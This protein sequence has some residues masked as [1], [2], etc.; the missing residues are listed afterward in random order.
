MIN[1]NELRMIKAALALIDHEGYKIID[2]R[3]I[4]KEIW[5]N[6][7][8]NTKELIRFSIGNGFQPTAHQDERTSAI[9]KAIEKIFGEKTLFYDV[10]FD[11]D[12]APTVKTEDSIA[13]TLAPSTQSNEF[14][15]RFQ[16][17]RPILMAV[18]ED[19]KILEDAQKRLAAERPKAAAPR[20]MVPP[21]ATLI[22]IILCSIMFGMNSILS[23]MGHYAFIDMSIFLGAYYKTLILSNNE[24]WRFFTSGFLHM[25]IY[26]LVM[27]MY[28]LYYLGLFYETK[29]GWKKMLATLFVGVIVGSAF[30]F[31]TE[32]NVVAVGM[33]GGLFAVLGSIV[34][35]M[36]ESGQIANKMVQRQLMQIL[37]INVFISLIPGVAFMAHLGGFLAGILIALYFSYKPSWKQLKIHVLISSLILSSALTYLIVNDKNYLPVTKLTDLRVVQIA[38]DYGLTWYSAELTR[39][40]EAFYQKENQ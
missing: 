29:F 17:L 31:V 7:P 1:Q 23:E 30:M 21:K 39:G 33:S 28:S 37:L 13:I 4:G 22:L 35:Y 25:D 18:E 24:Y 15:D 8:A 38:E 19:P 12:D 34:V 5:L 3:I 6:H 26:H 16:L 40:L 20:K 9:R 14:L 2:V 27:N 11:E 36:I 10:R 32:G